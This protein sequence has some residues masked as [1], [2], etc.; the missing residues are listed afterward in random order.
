MRKSLHFSAIDTEQTTTA[1]HLPRTQCKGALPYRLTGGKLRLGEI[2]VMWNIR[3]VGLF[4]LFGILVI[5]T[6]SNCME[7]VVSRL[8]MKEIVDHHTIN[9]GKVPRKLKCQL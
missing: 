3:N 7:A 9:E 2:G 6:V 1:S 4:V 5:M 8:D